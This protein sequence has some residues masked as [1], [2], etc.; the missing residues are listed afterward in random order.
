MFRLLDVNGPSRIFDTREDAELFQRQYSIRG[1]VQIVWD[2]SNCERCNWDD[3]IP[4][5]NCRTPDYVGHSRAHCTA[6]ACY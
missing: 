4:H 2:D 6:D 5:N 3:H 1:I